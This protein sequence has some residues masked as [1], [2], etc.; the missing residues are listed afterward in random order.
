[1]YNKDTHK[2]IEELGNEITIINNKIKILNK[3][4][5]ESNLYNKRFFLGNNKSTV[6]ISETTFLTASNEEIREL[7]S[8]LSK[9]EKDYEKALKDALDYKKLVCGIDYP[10]S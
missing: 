6:D 5:N 4:L 10:A 2:K 9:L 1:M 7:E 8:K 3:F